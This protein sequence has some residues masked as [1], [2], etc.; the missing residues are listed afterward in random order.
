LA[1][2]VR[3]SLHLLSGRRYRFI[4]GMNLQPRPPDGGGRTLR[5]PGRRAFTLIEL[6]TVIAIIAILASIAFGVMSGV[7]KR[8]AAQRARADLAVLAQAL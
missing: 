4:G 6:L 1:N 7:K 8:A 5:P 2:A 3:R